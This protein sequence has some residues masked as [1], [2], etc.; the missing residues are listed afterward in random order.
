MVMATENSV[1]RAVMQPGSWIVSGPIRSGFCLNW[2]NSMELFARRPPVFANPQAAMFAG[3]NLP[4][5]SKRH[6]IPY[7]ARSR[8]FQRHCRVA[9]SHKPGP[10]QTL[11]G[12]HGLRI[13]TFERVCGVT[14]VS[15]PAVSPISLS[16]ECHPDRRLSESSEPA[17][18][19]PGDTAGKETCVTRKGSRIFL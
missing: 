13:S 10:I 5:R 19:K 6:P 17:G 15:L 7:A 16:A 3:K 1:R 4:A 11:L 9:E 14:Q 2:K 18:W 8:P 12:E